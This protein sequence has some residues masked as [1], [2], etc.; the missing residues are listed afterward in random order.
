LVNF[1]FLVLENMKAYF[2]KS[3][4]LERD[5][6]SKV[7]AFA[8]ENS[9]ADRFKIAEE[10]GIGIGK[11]ASDGK[12][13]PTIQ[14]AVYSGLL[15]DESA[16]SKN[17]ISLSELG[18]I[19]FENDQRLKNSI[20]QWVMHYFLARTENE[21]LIWS[22]FVHEFLPQFPNFESDD[23]ERGLRDR[24]SDLSERINKE[25]RRIL[26]SCYTDGNALSKTGLLESYEKDK[27]IR[28]NSNQSN[29]YLAAY[30]LAE[31]WE[32]KHPEKSMIEPSALYESGHL[33]TTLNL[34]DGDLQNCLDEMSAIGVI[35]QMREAPPFQVVRR[36]TDKFDL[37]RRA[38][39][40]ER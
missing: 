15:T 13:Q 2:H 24:F 25:N 12:V 3:F 9:T 20:T 34:A 7:L 36:W 6:I 1:V 19:I 35:E 27:Y 37:L 29:P 28:G 32:A 22:F 4:I 26:T 18:K 33:V 40:V 30:I 8:S 11:S 17:N 14:Y 10:T 31:T 23:L 21:A 5:N 39:E 16:E 38:Y